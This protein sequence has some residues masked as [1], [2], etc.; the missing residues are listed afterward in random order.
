MIITTLGLHILSSIFD[1]DELLMGKK[2]KL[3]V[4]LVGLGKYAKDELAPALLQTEHCY[5]AA[6]V[7]GTP[8]QN[9]LLERK[10]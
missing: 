10:I 4:A 1:F 5:L 7:T 8:L 6:I 2:K 3:G 9:S